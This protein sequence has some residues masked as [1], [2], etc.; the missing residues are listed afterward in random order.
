[1]AAGA[2]ALE[3]EIRPPVTVII[4]SRLRFVRSIAVKVPLP[5][6]KPVCAKKAGIFDRGRYRP[7]CRPRR[8][9]S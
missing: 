7:A 2:I 4:H 8:S 3:A 5:L 6:R 9:A 1:M